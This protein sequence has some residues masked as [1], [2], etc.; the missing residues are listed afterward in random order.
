MKGF[1]IAM[2]LFVA[3]GFGLLT[4]YAKLGNAI[5]EKVALEEKGRENVMLELSK[6]EAAF[7]AK[8]QPLLDRRWS[9][10]TVA[11]FLDD[12]YFMALSAETLELYLDTPLMTSESYGQFMFERANRL[13]EVPQVPVQAQAFELYKKYVELFP[14]HKQAQ[15]ARNAISRMVTKYGMNP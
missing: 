13:A 8:F 2:A 10:A 12:V 6:N 1:L 11:R 9:V 7:G 4:S 3:A 5:I 14:T 15:M